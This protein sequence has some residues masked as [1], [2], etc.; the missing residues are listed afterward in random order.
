MDGDLPPIDKVP[1]GTPRVKRSE[2]F[3]LLKGV[4]AM[5]QAF[6]GRKRHKKY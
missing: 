6:R 3:P 1:R 4:T 5:E 2:P